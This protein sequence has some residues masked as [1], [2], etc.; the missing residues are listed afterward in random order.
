M[1]ETIAKNVRVVNVIRGGASK[2]LPRALTP[3]A[4]TWRAVL[5]FLAPTVETLTQYITHAGMLARGRPA[6]VKPALGRIRIAFRC[7]QDRV[8]YDDA[9]YVASLRR[10]PIAAALTARNLA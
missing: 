8:P 1:F 4:Q 2:G 6:S 3:K 5:G 9:R 7:W 10:H